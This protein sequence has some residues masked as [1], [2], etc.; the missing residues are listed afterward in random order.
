[1]YTLSYYRDAEFLQEDD[2]EVPTIYGERGAKSEK[3][4]LFNA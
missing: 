3:F 4:L 2:T 1:M